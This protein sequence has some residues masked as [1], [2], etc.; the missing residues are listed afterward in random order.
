[1]KTGRIL[2][3]TALLVVAAVIIFNKCNT[4]KNTGAAPAQ[5]GSPQP[6]IVNGIIVS[7]QPLEEKIYASGTLL[8]NDEVEIRNEIAGRITSL[9]F[10]EGTR[11]KKGQLLLTIYDDDITAQL[12]KLESQKAIAQKT[13]ERQEDLIKVNGISQQEYELAQ[14][15]LSSIQA[16]L[17]LVQSQIS[18]T[19]I[20]APFDGVIG[21]RSVSVGAYLPVNTLIANMQAVDPLKIEFSVPEKYRSMINDTTTIRFTTES[22]EGTFTGKIFA[23]EP[24]IDLQTRSVFVRALCPNKENKLFPGSFAH[25]EI[26]LKRLDK[27]VLIPTQ[28]LMP[29]IRGEKVFVVRNDSAR[30]VDVETG[31]RNDSTVQVISGLSEGDTV[32]TTGMMQV[33][34][35]SPLKVKVNAPITSR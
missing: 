21:L 7:L 25:I 19:K 30:K 15:E 23:F 9:L 14:N 34:P 28:S 11:V 27:A 8:A 33:R 17:D 2:L 32:L 29:E 3:I 31:I 5:A 22:A 6:L 24:K 1:L 18:K 26:P 16:D 4:G 35:G 12:R 10:K 13:V 20:R